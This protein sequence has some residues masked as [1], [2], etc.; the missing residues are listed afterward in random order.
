MTQTNQE[1]RFCPNCIQMTNHQD[2]ECLKCGMEPSRVTLVKAKG[3]GYFLAVGDGK[4]KN[5]WA[6]TR[7]E[8]ILIYQLSREELLK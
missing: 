2:E 7:E 1:L 3:N 6:I 8:L 5:T 4:S